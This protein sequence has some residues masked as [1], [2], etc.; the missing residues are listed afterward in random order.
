[1]QSYQGFRTGEGPKHK[2][3]AQTGRAFAEAADLMVVTNSPEARLI[4]VH[5]ANKQ[6]S[7]EPSIVVKSPW[8]PHRRGFVVSREKGG[9]GFDKLD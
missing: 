6:R 1:M 4:Q 3:S 7:Q 8:L 2:I 9:S 5:M